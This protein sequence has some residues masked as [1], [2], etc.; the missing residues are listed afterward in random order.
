M[1]EI[2]TIKNI[3]LLPW[4]QYGLYHCRSLKKMN[5]YPFNGVYID[6]A[7]CHYIFKERPYLF[8]GKLSLLNDIFY[9]Q[10]GTNKKY[11]PEDV[12]SLKIEIDQFLIKISKLKNYI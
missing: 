1:N 7:R 2:L 4:K 6:Y 12:E 8:V 3:S 10:Q 9:F 5:I 11:Y